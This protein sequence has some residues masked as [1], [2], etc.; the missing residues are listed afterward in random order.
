MYSFNTTGNL[1]ED[2]VALSSYVQQVAKIRCKFGDNPP[3]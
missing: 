2:F 1:I 3:S